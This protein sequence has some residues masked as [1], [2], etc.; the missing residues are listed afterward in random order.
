MPEEIATSASSLLAT[1]F[2]EAQV[3]GGAFL[4]EM[5]PDTF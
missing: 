3:S 2:S 5:I 1:K 4:K